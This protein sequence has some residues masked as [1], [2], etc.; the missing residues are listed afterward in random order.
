MK[1]QVKTAIVQTL[2]NYA[3]ASSYSHLEFFSSI[4]VLRCMCLI[5]RRQCYE[6]GSNIFC[7]ELKDVVNIFKHQR[8]SN[9]LNMLYIY[10]LLHAKYTQCPDQNVITALAVMRVSG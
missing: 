7:V 10:S 4:L 8:D 9:S 6:L 1:L 3:F 2:Q 5:F